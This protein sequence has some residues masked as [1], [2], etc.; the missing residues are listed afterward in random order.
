MDNSNIGL[1]QQVLTIRNTG[2]VNMLDLVSVA[3]LAER[4]GLYELCK[5]VKEQPEMYVNFIMTGEM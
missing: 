2:L 1:R 3:V 4:Y 5:F